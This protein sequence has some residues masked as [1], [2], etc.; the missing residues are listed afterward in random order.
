MQLPEELQTIIEQLAHQSSALK[1]AR[2]ELTKA[3]QEGSNSG[4]LFCDEA[5]MLA[6]LGARMPATYA[7]AFTVFRHLQ[8]RL[9]DFS[10]RHL[11]DLGAGP[12]TGLWA[13]AQSFP[14]LQK[15]T[16]IE[17]S[18]EAISL[19]KQLAFAGSLPLFQNVQWHSASLEAGLLLPESDLAILSYVLGELPQPHA[20]IEH[21]WK[22]RLSHLVIIEPGT[23]K[24]FQRIRSAREQLL[25]MG[26]FL[27]AP[28]PHPFSCP[29]QGTD[30]CHFSARVERTRLHRQL[31]E[32]SLGYEDEKF[33]YLIVSREPV[34]PSPMGRIVRP[35]SKQSGFVRVPLCSQE[36]K[37]VEKTVT[38]SQKEIYRQARDAEW[39]DAW[40]Q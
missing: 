6:Y 22:S 40:T 32:G 19:G 34:P 18:L 23:P 9:P 17:Q 8:E 7:A 1:R 31:K 13:A 36:G 26:A 30:W 12:G 2:V 4:S 29:I 25:K 3:Y 20:W 28:C 15:A 16:L 39:G 33:S 37:L 14:S 27:I 38:R 10:P 5:K 11:L 24:G 35:P 21:C